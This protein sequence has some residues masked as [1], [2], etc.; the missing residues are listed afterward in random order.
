MLNQGAQSQLVCFNN[1]NQIGV[2]PTKLYLE[3]YRIG[4]IYIFTRLAQI[5]ISVFKPAVIDVVI[6]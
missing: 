3:C 1:R 5:Y 6:S 4:L 2:I